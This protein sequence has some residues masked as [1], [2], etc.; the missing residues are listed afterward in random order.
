MKMAFGLSRADP[1][2]K[3]MASTALIG[4][5]AFVGV[6]VLG[7]PLIAVAAGLAPLSI[8]LAWMQ[9]EPS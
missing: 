2:W 4:V 1:R 5:S 8:A 9:S 3:P 6:G 7:W